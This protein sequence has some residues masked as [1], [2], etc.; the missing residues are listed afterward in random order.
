MFKPTLL[1]TA[2]KSATRSTLPFNPTARASQT[3]LRRTL[4]HSYR[5][6]TTSRCLRDPTQ[7]EYDAATTSGKPYESGDHE[8][9]FARTD[10]GVRIEHPEEE[11]MPSSAP[12]SGRGGVH[13]MRT[14]A[15][16]SLEG[17]VGVVTGGARG[18]GLV[19]S[20][21]LVISGADVAIVDMNSGGFP[22]LVYPTSILT[23]L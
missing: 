13:N 6:L 5:L 22:I 2:L 12:V 10:H 11:H 16:F 17:K 4:P 7:Q 23:K 18:L 1:Q 21:A 15:S 19:M 20:Q 14:V 8:G 3:S 9:Q